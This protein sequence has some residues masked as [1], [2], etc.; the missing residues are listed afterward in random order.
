MKVSLTIE[1]EVEPDKEEDLTNKEVANVTGMLT[2]VARNRLGALVGRHLG[3][4]KRAT[5]WEVTVQNVEVV[6]V[7]K[8]K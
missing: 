5:G 7:S 3:G 6:P 2:R 1:F 8:V 4:E